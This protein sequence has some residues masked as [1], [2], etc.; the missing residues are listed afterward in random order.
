MISKRSTQKSLVP[1]KGGLLTPAAPPPQLIT[2]KAS[3]R[4][5]SN[6]TVRN[7]MT[8]LNEE[9][10]EILKSKTG[11][12]FSLKFTE[13]DDEDAEELQA[14]VEVEEDADAEADAGS[15]EYDPQDALQIENYY[16]RKGILR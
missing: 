4:Q 9:V 2:A 11:K 13:M 10:L 5:A 15:G 7:S 12:L 8:P 14:E 6:Y 1:S 3:G 16:Q